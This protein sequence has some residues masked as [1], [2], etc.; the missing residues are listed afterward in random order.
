MFSSK[1]RMTNPRRCRPSWIVRLLVPP[2]FCAL[3]EMG[4]MI[5]RLQCIKTVKPLWW[6]VWKPGPWNHGFIVELGILEM[7]TIALQSTV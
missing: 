3:G 2:R 1:G 6:L 5:F 7:S 4:E